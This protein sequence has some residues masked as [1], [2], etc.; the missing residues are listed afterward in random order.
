MNH[1]IKLPR[2]SDVLIEI[3]K[4]QESKRYCQRL[5]RRI[6]GSLTHLREVVRW[7]AQNNLVII[8][9]TSKVKQLALTEKGERIAQYIIRMK[10][11]FSE[12]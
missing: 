7:L 5:N 1:S 10:L 8:T 11:E 4:S 3:Y 9:P 2:W 6:Q 12:L